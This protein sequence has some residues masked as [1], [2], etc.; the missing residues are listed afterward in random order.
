CDAL[1]VDLEGAYA[2]YRFNEV[3][4]LLY[5]FL[6]AEF[7]DKFLEAV[8]G[9]LRD[10]APAE[11]TEAT[12]A[13]FDAVMARFLQSLHPYMPHLTEELSSRMGYISEGEFLMQKELPSEGL[14]AGIAEEVVATGREQASAIYETAGKLRNLKAEYRVAAR[15]DV[16]FVAKSG[17]AWLEAEAVTLSL[18][19]GAESVT[20]DADYAPPQGTPGAVTGAGEIFMPMEGLIDVEAEKARLDKEIEKIGKEVTKCGNKLGN[21]RF[22]ANAKPEVVAVERERLEEWQGKLAQLEKMRA[23]LS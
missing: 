13:V 4:S 7:C 21:E 14:L 11:A 16:R 1:A 10:D 22:V 6:W 15:K 12:L 23:V 9:D 2:D 17:P 5:D 18:L 20:R 19:V 8:K 3:G